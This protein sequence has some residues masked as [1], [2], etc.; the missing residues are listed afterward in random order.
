M[1]PARPRGPTFRRHQME[2]QQLQP[3]SLIVVDKTQYKVQFYDPELGLTL[4]A[5]LIKTLGPPLIKMFSTFKGKSLD[6]IM[7]LDTKDLDFDVLGD[8]VQ[9]IFMQL[10]PEEVT[11]LVKEILGST[12]DGKTNVNVVEDFSVRFMGKY[13]HLFKLVGKTL[14]AQYPDFLGGILKRMNAAKSGS[15]SVAGNTV[16]SPL[17]LKHTGKS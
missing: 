1:G 11:P 10:S 17:T 6:G 14:G 4:Y 15:A 12:F 8:A 13:S 5:K 16:T 7:N 9:S 2:A 3:S